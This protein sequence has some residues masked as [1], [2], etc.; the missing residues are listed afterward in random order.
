MRKF[1]LALAFFAVATLA[2]PAFLAAQ[3]P[4]PKP[5][6]AETAASAEW[7]KEP[8]DFRG[9]KFGSDFDGEAMKRAGI[10]CSSMEP[11]SRWCSSIL[12]LANVKIELTFIFKK[13]KFVSVLLE[14]DPKDWDELK[15]IL[16]E[17][18]GEPA[19]S[20]T[21]VLTN[22]FGAT[23]LNEKMTWD[24]ARVYFQAAKYG[25]SLD[26]GLAG[27]TLESHIADSAKEQEQKRKKAADAL[28]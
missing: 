11:G 4:A 6:T 12:T 9:I 20:E 13:E 2:L 3:T 22:A 27:M 25:S 5:A 8:E 19:R 17:R 24:G 26:K 16:V 10:R 15:P 18:Y 1:P 21:G 23:F 14:Y 7:P 28:K